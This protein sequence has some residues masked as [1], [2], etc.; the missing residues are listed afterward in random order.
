MNEPQFHVTEARE[1][2]SSVA[3]HDG[4]EAFSEAFVRGLDGSHEHFTVRDH[5]TLIALAGLAPDGSA[6]VAVHPAYRRLGHGTALISQTLTRRPDAGLWAH[7]NLAAARALAAALG[8]KP[9]RE[10]LVMAVE[11]EALAG[12]GAP[13]STAEALTEQEGIRE[14]SYAE[15]P[16]GKQWLQVNNEAFHWHPEQGGWDLARLHE[17][18]NTEWFDPEGVRFLFDGDFLAGFH[19]TKRHS[20]TLGEVYVVGV[21]DAYRGR[22]LGDP[23]MRA[24]VE[25]LV[26]GGARKVILYVEADNQPAVKRYEQLGFAVVERHVVYKSTKLTHCSPI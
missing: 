13:G 10:L 23:L 17:A 16:A 24:G 22:G 7:G 15:E 2:L 6:E 8:L 21:A 11:G 14:S 12:I 5:N 26:A 3:Q 4:V 9:T 18:M 1:L 19:W 20:D 25:H